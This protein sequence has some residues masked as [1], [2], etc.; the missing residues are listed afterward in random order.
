ML[1]P[2]TWSV[3]KFNLVTFTLTSSSKVMQMKRSKLKLC[4]LISH[5]ITMGIVR[6]YISLPIW[7]HPGVIQE[8]L[9][10]IYQVGNCWAEYMDGIT[11]IVSFWRSPGYCNILFS[12]SLEVWLRFWYSESLSVDCVHVLKRVFTI[13]ERNRIKL[14]IYHMLTECIL[15]HQLWM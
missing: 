2:I 5:I 11:Y 4:C 9:I 12:T 6:L 10:P 13:L 15:W 3:V 1:R 7:G 8:Y 14:N